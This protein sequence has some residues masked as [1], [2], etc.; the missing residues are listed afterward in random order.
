MTYDVENR[1][2]SAQYT[3][4]VKIIHKTTYSYSGD[5]LL[6]VT[7]KYEGT[8]TPLTL[9]DTVRYIRDGLLFRGKVLQPDIEKM[10]DERPVRG[11]RGYQFIPR[12][13][14]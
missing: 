13:S 7:R 9:K 10:V 2:T 4:S 11:K 14:E 12:D 6:A 1:I 8:A 5:G 3:D